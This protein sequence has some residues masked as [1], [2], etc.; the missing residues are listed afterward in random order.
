VICIVQGSLTL[1][2]QA[3]APIPMTRMTNKTR[4]AI[5]R[6]ILASL[7]CAAVAIPTWGQNTMSREQTFRRT[8]PGRSVLTFL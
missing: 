1:L 7:A 4:G 5:V 2:I 6:L 8:H 3:P